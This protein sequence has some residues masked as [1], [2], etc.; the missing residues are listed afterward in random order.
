MTITQM[1]V[2]YGIGS[3]LTGALFGFLTKRNTDADVDDWIATGLITL[4]WPL[5]LCVF[6]VICAVYAVREGLQ[7]FSV[8]RDMRKL[9]GCKAVR[10][11]HYHKLLM[12]VSNSTDVYWGGGSASVY[13][14][15]RQ[16]RQVN[17]K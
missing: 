8:W 7:D 15:V 2:A 17:A 16:F 3:V 6:G 11:K 10:L 4:T 12:G 13:A 9:K 1:L 5:G 14:R